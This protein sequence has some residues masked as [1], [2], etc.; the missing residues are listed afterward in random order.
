[1]G[2]TAGNSL[3]IVFDENASVEVDVLPVDSLSLRGICAMM[4]DAEGADFEVLLG[5]TNLLHRSELRAISFEW[6]PTLLHSIGQ[7]PFAILNLL[8]D[9]GFDLFFDDLRGPIDPAEWRAMA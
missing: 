6:V 9:A 1:M 2:N 5:A 3:W 8:A 7:D 4:I